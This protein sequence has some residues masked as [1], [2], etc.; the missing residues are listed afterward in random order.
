ML[1]PNARSLYTAALRPPQGY[2]LDLAVATTYSLELETLLGI[3]LHLLL[4]AGDADAAALARDPIALL[5]SLRRIAGRIHVFHHAGGVRPPDRGSVLYALLEP[6][7]HSARAPGGGAFHPKLWALRFTAPDGPPLYRVLVLSRNLTGD[8]SWDLVLQMDGSAG[9][10]ARREN[11]ALVAL[12][13]ALPGL[14]GLPKRRRP[15]SIEHLAEDLGRVRW[16]LPHGF[17]QARFL[18]LGLGTSGWRLAPCDRLAVVSPFCSDGALEMLAGVAGEPA[19]LLSRP[20]DLAE[21]KPSTLARFGSVLVLAEAAETEDGE[22]PATAGR[23]LGLHAKV[24]LAERGPD[25]HLYVGSANASDAALRLDRN[26]EL[27]VELSGAR[28]TVGGIDDFLG[29]DGIGSFVQPV[30]PGETAAPDPRRALAER[31][32]ERARDAIAST[33]LDARCSVGDAG[34]QVELVPAAPIGMEGVDTARCWLVSQDPTSAADALP[35]RDGAALLFPFIPLAAITGLVAFELHAAGCDSPTRFVV[36]ASLSGVSVEERQTAI[37]RDVVRDE[38]HFLTY[39]RMLLI[40]DSAGDAANTGAGAWSAAAGSWGNGG[41]ADELP[42]VEDLTRAL[43]RAPERL[44]DVDA[45]IRDLQGSSDAEM[46]VPV[47]FLEMW[48]VFR[49]MIKPVRNR[50]GT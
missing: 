26:V 41:P 47:G 12:V 45:L 21:R 1:D 46:P 3:P 28:S 49:R 10:S 43:C 8:A 23:L 25:T 14:A 24:Y 33:A 39:L 42:L 18:T 27:M 38:E 36:Q 19:A 16:D 34:W 30:S 17:R 5:E 2:R 32:L 50:R 15:G 6:V 48:E 40:L 20:E 44:R 4:H 37:V 22:D 29:P 31:V 35:L 13:K 11:D 9:P 7:I